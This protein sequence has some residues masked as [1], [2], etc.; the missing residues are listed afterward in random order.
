[1]RQPPEPSHLPS[2][3]QLLAPLSAH[4]LRG[5]IEPAE[6][7]A[8]VPIDEG[9]A[10]L[11]QAPPHASAQ[12]TPS[13]QKLL[14]QSPAAAQ[15]CPSGLRPQLTPLQTWPLTQSASRVQR[16]MH[17]PLLQ[18]NGAQDCTPGGRQAPTPSHVQ[19]VL[20]RSALH[21]GATQTVSAA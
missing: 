21:D 6:I 19:A 4:T 9:R 16:A 13:T 8:H 14:T 18:R 5:S 15:G 7:G 17:A 20:S 3:P 2:V 11:R 12:Q 10:Q 1:L